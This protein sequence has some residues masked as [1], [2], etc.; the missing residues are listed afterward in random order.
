MPDLPVSAAIHY[1]ST[2]PTTSCDTSFVQGHVR[3]KKSGQFLAR[4]R[5]NSALAI[6]RHTLLAMTFTSFL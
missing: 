2:S 1:A 4:G 3:N 5:G 6:F